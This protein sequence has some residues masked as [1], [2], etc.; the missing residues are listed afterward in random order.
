VKHAPFWVEDHPRAEGITTDLPQ[1]TDYLIVGSGLTGLS[2][3]LRLVGSGKTVTVID[4]GDIASG[5]SSING[6]MVS[7]DVKAGMVAVFERYGPE[8][9]YEMWDSTVRSIELVR[10]LASRPEIDA[11]THDHGMAAL[12]TGPR[13]RKSLENMVAWYQKTLG[14]DWEILGRPDI[15]KV[16]G[17]DHFDVAMYE[18]EGFGVHPARLVFGVAREV[19]KAGAA[20]V[21]QC[22]ALGIEPDLRRGRD[23]RHQRVHDQ[24]AEP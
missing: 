3:A 4:A 10:E 5:A 1:E 13:K 7:P 20:L 15:G 23:H 24:A 17:G 21:D 19:E 14:V 18:P 2:A 6:G 22:R 9:G 8:I 12:G 11:L 16:V